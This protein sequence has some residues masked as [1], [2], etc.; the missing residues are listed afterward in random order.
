[1]S[2]PDIF[3]MINSL[4]SS[5]SSNQQLNNTDTNNNNNNNNNTTAQISNAQIL[6]NANELYTSNEQTFNN[7]MQLALQSLNQYYTS[8]K[9]SQVECELYNQYADKITGLQDEILQTKTDYNTNDRKSYY[10]TQVIQNLKYWHTLLSIAFKFLALGLISSLFLSPNSLSVIKKIVIIMALLLYNY[11]I[12]YIA[13][14]YMSV[15]SYTKLLL[16]KNV[17]TNL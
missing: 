14:Y 16:P 2:N 4:S 8:L 3:A 15:F 12:S 13:K 6:A 7:N 1:M 17:Y 5:V 10:E 9:Y 11:Y